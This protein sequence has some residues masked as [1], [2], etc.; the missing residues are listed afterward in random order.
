MVAVVVGPEGSASEGVLL[1]LLLL[2]LSSTRRTSSESEGLKGGVAG[3]LRTPMSIEFLE[4]SVAVI[5]R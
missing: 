3:G 5:G 2:S 4:M 1:L